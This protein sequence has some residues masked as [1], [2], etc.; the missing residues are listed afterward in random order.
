MTS[1]SPQRTSTSTQRELRSTD[2][3]TDGPAPRRATGEGW[4][5]FAGI[6]LFAAGLMRL[7]D[8]LWAF[9]YHGVV[10]NDLQDALFGHSLNT[11][12]WLWVGVAVILGLA[13]IGVLFRNQIGRWVGVG[14]GVIGSVTAIWWMPY[15]PVWSLMY[16][17]IGILVVYALVAHG[18]ATRAY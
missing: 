8:A 17:G 18:E 7:F 6:A 11:Y 13:G 16:V 12:G 3:P 10:P 15:Y 14:A 5:I 9:H 1:T 2:Y 4:L